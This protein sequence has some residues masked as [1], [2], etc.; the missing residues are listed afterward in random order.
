MPSE[1][2][3]SSNCCSS[4]PTAFYF[5]LHPE[6]PN[7]C[8]WELCKDGEGPF[9]CPEATSHAQVDAAQPLNL[10]TC[11]TERMAMLG[12]LMLPKPA[13]HKNPELQTSTQL[14]I[15]HPTPWPWS[16]Y[17]YARESHASLSRGMSQS[18]SS[19]SSMQRQP[20]ASHISVFSIIK[21]GVSLHNHNSKGIFSSTVR[22]RR[23][24][25]PQI[26]LAGPAYARSTR[27][28]STA[29]PT[30]LF[31]APHFSGPPQRKRHAP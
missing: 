26:K 22:Q 25:P 19:P 10:R 13:S 2:K 31:L 3:T 6:I 28:P 23:S 29:A 15:E 18:R 30:D 8:F 17:R 14:P 4:R 5:P 24:C 20:A 1:T 12:F 7:C 27:L 16:R 21:K 11:Q 9:L